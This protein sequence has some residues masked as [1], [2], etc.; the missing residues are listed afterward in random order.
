MSTQ[1]KFYSPL[2]RDFREIEPN[3]YQRIIRFYE[4][5][6][7][8]I[9]RL[10][11]GEYFDLT[12][13]Y[14]DAL[15]ETGAYRRHLLLVDGVIIASIE[16]NVKYIDGQDIY[17]G[18]LFRK[19]ASAYRLEDYALAEHI[20]RELLRMNPADKDAFAF[21]HK[22][23]RVRYR[24]WLQLGRALTIIALLAAAGVIAADVLYVRPFHPFYLPTMAWTRNLLFAGGLLALAVC[25]G[26][27]WGLAYRRAVGFR[28]E[29]EKRKV[30]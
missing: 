7:A 20:L 19:A 4:E 21:L 8:E 12:A 28:R 22:T 29:Q 6:E 11:F 27:A 3:D 14:V 24:R 18:M 23:L 9:G 16:Y 25:Y 2:Y 15:F 30:C 13:A 10:D 17:R 1:Q 26:L 5:K